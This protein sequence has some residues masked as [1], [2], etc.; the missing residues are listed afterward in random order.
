[1]DGGAKS[2]CA[3]IGDHV[4]SEKKMNQKSICHL[5]TFRLLH[6]WFEQSQATDWK[7]QVL[8]ASLAIHDSATLTGTSLA[9]CP[10][11]CHRNAGPSVH[12]SPFSPFLFASHFSFTDVHLIWTLQVLWRLL[13]TQLLM[14][15][16]LLSASLQLSSLCL[17]TAW[18]PV[19]GLASNFWQSVSC[20]WLLYCTWVAPVV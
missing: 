11:S 13:A 10:H 5:L 15:T 18:C 8:V 4:T 16:F 6:S 12:S 1:M 2:M 19:L 7:L 3:G 9:C 14:Y 20:L 17:K